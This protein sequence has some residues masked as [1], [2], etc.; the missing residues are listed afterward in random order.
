MVVVGLLSIEL[1]IPGARS[2]KEKRMVL[3]G[4]KDRIK[5]FNVAVAEVEYQ[6]LWQ[7]SGL[8]VATVSNDE[9]HA[10]QELAAV[11]NEIE[12]LEPGLITRTEVEFL[13]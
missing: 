2:L 6:D 3:R 9:R 10:D 7:R 8:S 4:V 12:R 5:K 11:V 1:H 13:K